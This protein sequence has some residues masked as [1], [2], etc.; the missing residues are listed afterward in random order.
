MFRLVCLSFKGPLVYVFNN[1]FIRKYNYLVYSDSSGFEKNGYEYLDYPYFQ[2]FN[3]SSVHHRIGV[4][5]EC[6]FRV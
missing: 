3:G 6:L 1:I 4:Y 5:L 2:I